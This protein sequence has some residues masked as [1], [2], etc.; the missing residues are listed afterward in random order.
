MGTRFD[1]L[2]LV[3]TQ[4]AAAA[5]LTEAG[6]IAGN[7]ATSP[8]DITPDKIKKAMETYQAILE[9]IRKHEE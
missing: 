9:A 8:N 3:A 6:R 2:T 4:I 1:K 7:S 5:I